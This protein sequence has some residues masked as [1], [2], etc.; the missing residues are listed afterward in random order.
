MCAL[1]VPSGENIIRQRYIATKMAEHVTD[2]TQV[3]AHTHE[4]ELEQFDIELELGEH[5]EQVFTL[6]GYFYFVVTEH[7]LKS[8][9]S[10]SK[11]ELTFC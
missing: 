9:L 8:I 4:H 11:C 7:A 5:H 6:F 1:F 3:H 10:S 2:S